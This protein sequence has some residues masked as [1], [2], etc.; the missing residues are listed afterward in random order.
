MNEKKTSMSFSNS[1]AVILAAGIGSR[2]NS[3]RPKVMHEIAGRSMISHVIDTAG[4][5]GINRISA[6]IGPEAGALAD[7]IEK[8]SPKTGIVIQNERLGTAHAVARARDEIAAGAGNVLVLYGDTP[9]I[10]PATLMRMNEALQG[11]DMVVLGFEAAK[12][13]GYGR[14]LLAKDGSLAA[15]REDAEASAAEKLVNLCNSGV[16]AFGNNVLPGLLDAIGNDNSKGEYYLTDAVEIART[17]GLKCAVVTAEEDELL[18]VNSRDQLALAESIMQERLRMAAMANGATLQDP[19]S[20]YF[21]HDTV[22]GR[23]VMVEPCVFF[24]SGV[25]IGDN[26]HI[27]GFC[28][29]EQTVIK[30]GAVV[31]PYARLRPGTELGCDVKVGNFVEIKKSTISSGAKVSHLSYIGDARIGE[32]ANIGAGTITCNYDGFNKHLTQIGAGAFIGSNSALVAP[33]KIGDGAYIGSG[34]VVTKN[35]DGDALA[36]ARAKQVEKPGWAAAFRA[37]NAKKG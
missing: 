8:I 21:S 20:V 29:I 7:E 35:V 1:H 6:V 3:S 11:S 30:S 32:G 36:V 10:T 37:R 31:G 5:A 12:P 24:G 16:M 18:G 27:K 19:G 2:M 14:L 34:S 22:L 33:V 17:R 28:H 4:K 9:L 26:V 13:A 23:D 15:I 25:C